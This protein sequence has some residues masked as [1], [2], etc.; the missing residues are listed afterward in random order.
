MKKISLYFILVMFLVIPAFSVTV[1]MP[2]SLGIKNGTNRYQIY[3]GIKTSVG[4]GGGIGV[5]ASIPILLDT[6]TGRTWRYFRNQ[7]ETITTT[8]IIEGITVE[9]PTEV[10]QKGQLKEGWTPLYYAK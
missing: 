2:D 5:G 6:M 7:G 1:I 9:V 10:F 3:E 4:G 8:K